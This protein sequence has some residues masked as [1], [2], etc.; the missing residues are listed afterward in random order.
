[1]E[2]HNQEGLFEGMAGKVLIR[3]YK[4]TCARAECPT[5][6]ESWAGKEASRIEHRLRMAPKK[7]RP[8][9][10]VVSPCRDDVLGLNYEALRRKCYVVLKKARFL[11]GS[12]IFHP[13]REDESS[14]RWY[15]SPHFHALG[16]GW[17]QNVKEGYEAHG[18]IVK[19]LGLR[20]TVAGTALYQL[21]HAGIHEKRHTVTWFG[22]LSYN[23]LNVPA[24][25][26]PEELCPIC[27]E[28]LRELWYVG[29][30]PFPVPDQ[31]GDFWV[32]PEGWMYKPQR[33]RYG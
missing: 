2:G 16:F 10:V 30:G 13:F 9:H 21:S 15:F 23:K 4:R 17:I 29:P 1:M 12:V 26:P 7:S 11:G 3:R 27:R 24:Q 31:E 28:K 18:W 5:C 22:S 25:D 19:N 8:I 14:K 20:K 6:Y 33:F 32:G